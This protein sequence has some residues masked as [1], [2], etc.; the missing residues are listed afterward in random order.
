M[1]FARIYINSDTREGY[2][3]LFKSFFA[4]ANEKLAAFNLKIQWHH[5]HGTGLK[6]IVSDMCHKQ[7]A[8]NYSIRI[9]LINKY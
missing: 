4:L 3:Y 5:I 2:A 1:V 7:A 8:G 9:C 6:V